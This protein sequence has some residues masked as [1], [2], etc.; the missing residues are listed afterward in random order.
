V[1]FNSD[2][3][4]TRKGV[5]H[6]VK[7]LQQGHSFITRLIPLIH[8]LLY[9]GIII[10][11]YFQTVRSPSL[12]VP[13]SFKL[14]VT[15]CAVCHSDKTVS[16]WY[17]AEQCPALL[18]NFSS[19]SRNSWHTVSLLASSTGSTDSYKSLAD[20]SASLDPTLPTKHSS[21]KSSSITIA[22]MAVNTVASHSTMC[23]NLIPSSTST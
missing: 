6:D 13:R 14:L 5:Y 20:V 10:Y 19:Y 16:I 7:F 11:I 4:A 9:Q 3:V 22:L 23:S 18:C 15:I 8:H 21:T 17:L 12:L 2:N 1:G